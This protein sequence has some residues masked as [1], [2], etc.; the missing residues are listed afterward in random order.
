MPGLAGELGGGPQVR[1]SVMV[2]MQVD[3]GGGRQQR[4][5][6]ADDQQA[7]VPGQGGPGVQQRPDVPE[8]SADPAQQLT[9]RGV[10]G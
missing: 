10:P 5:P 9:R 4:E 8:V 6:A 1:G 2:A 3:Q 7:A